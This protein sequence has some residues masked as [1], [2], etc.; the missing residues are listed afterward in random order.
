MFID[1]P[2]GVFFR[3]YIRKTSD[4]SRKPFSPNHQ[5]TFATSFKQQRISSLQ[6]R[7]FPSYSNSRDISRHQRYV[8]QL[9]RHSCPRSSFSELTLASSDSKHPPPL[10]LA[11]LLR[12]LSLLKTISSTSNLLTFTCSGVSGS[13]TLRISPTLPLDGKYMTNLSIRSVYDVGV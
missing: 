8:S 7:N 1:H 5:I 12:S 13:R 3:R 6:S 2:G 10:L 9:P 11:R 4:D